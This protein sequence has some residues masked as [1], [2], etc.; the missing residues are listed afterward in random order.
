MKVECSRMSIGFETVDYSCGCSDKGDKLDGQ[1]VGQIERK[2]CDGSI[3]NGEFNDHY[4]ERYTNEVMGANGFG[5]FTFPNGDWHEGIY[6]DNVANGKG[7]FF[8]SN[9]NIY[10]RG[11]YINN[12]P[13]GDGLF[14]KKNQT[15]S[16][17][18]SLYIGHGIVRI[19]PDLDPISTD[20]CTRI[21]Q[22]EAEWDIWEYWILEC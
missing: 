4:S 3:Y 10:W 22:I 12:M 19:V 20:N 9:K 16:E 8:H 6:R 14:F 11:E 17:E 2:W 7:V 5:R 15:T 21:K 1:F 18:E 13:N